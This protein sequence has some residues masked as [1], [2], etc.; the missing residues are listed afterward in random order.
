MLK[1]KKG[2]NPTI[3][4]EIN[5]LDGTPQQSDNKREALEEKKKFSYIMQNKL[6][7][8]SSLEHGYFYF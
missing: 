1:K 7:V 4:V 6:N 2:K 5:N 8:H 3:N